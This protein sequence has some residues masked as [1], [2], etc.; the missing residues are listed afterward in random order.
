MN[1]K[2]ERPKNMA[3]NSNRLSNELE[4]NFPN[5]IDALRSMKRQYNIKQSIK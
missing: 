4:H 1:F 3:L 2:A 5:V